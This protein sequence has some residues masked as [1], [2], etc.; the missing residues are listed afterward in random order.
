MKFADPQLLIALLLVPL[1]VAGYLYVQRRRSRY[2]VRFTNVD[3]LSNLA[4]RTPAWRRHVPTALYLVAIGALVI[5]LARPSMVLAV[6]REQATI[7]LTMD[8]SRSM[9]ATDVNP[10]RLAAAQKAASDFV[11]QLPVSFKVG[12]VVFSTESRIVITP[13]LDRS[14]IHDAID[15]LVADGGT[16]L[17]DAIVSSL[18]A[19][20]LT[21][22][23]GPKVPVAPS[24]PANASPSAPPAAGSPAPSASGAPKASPGASQPPLVATVLLSDG[25]NS[26]GT[27]QPLDAARQAAALGVPIYTIALGTADG[28]VAVPNQ[29]GQLRQMSV[30]PDPET[31]AA[32]AEM[33]G[34][35]SF[36]APT[37]A[38]LAQIYQSLGSRVGFTNEEREVTQWFAAA[39]LVLVLAGAGLAAHWFNRFP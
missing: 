39:G 24:P 29:Q 2:T 25:A 21:V 38:D 36:T 27:L 31:L 9:R 34:G 23:S 12:L 20:G 35:R 26:T 22:S 32:I 13:T 19:A 8:V 14:A 10:T 17:G 5:A 3:L 7:I 30:P 16:A 4:P 11:N 33:T 18:K 28:V 15:A 1:A 6:P 37:S